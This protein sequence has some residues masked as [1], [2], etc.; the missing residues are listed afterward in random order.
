MDTDDLKKFIEIANCGNLQR[1][2]VKLNVTAGALSKVVKR[3]ENTLGTT[4]FDR[5]GRNI[6]LNSQGAKF[7]QYALHIVHETEQ[8]ISEFIGADHTTTVK[9]SGPAILL[10]HQLSDIVKGLHSMSLEFNVDAVWE[11]QA[12]SHVSTGQSH[13]AL[14]TKAGLQEH[15]A[16]SELTSISLGKT[17]YCVVAGKSHPIINS[18]IDGNVS[19]EG[20][21]SFGFACP[22][23]SPLCGIRRG[24]GSDGWHDEK[25]PRYIQYRCNDFSTLISLVRRGLALA[26]VPEFVATTE[27]LATINIVESQSCNEEE[28]VLVYKPSLAN[29]WLNRLMQTLKDIAQ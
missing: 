19:M 14:V 13:L 2:S 27:E 25:M 8:A 28:V 1:A 29:G 24:M 5:I 10:Q 11:G 18:L 22:N 21:S 3:L 17:T 20:L 4:L 7:R 26:Y 23:V 16:R 15:G 6:V 9:L 12:L